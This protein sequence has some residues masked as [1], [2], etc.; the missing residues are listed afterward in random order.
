VP[1]SHAAIPA[2]ILAAPH[3]AA[4]LGGITDFDAVPAALP[5]TTLAL[6]NCVINLSFSSQS[7]FRQG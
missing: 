5:A 4:I 3:D 6:C 2:R 1:L 7:H